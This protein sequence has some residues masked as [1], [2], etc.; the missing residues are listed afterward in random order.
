VEEAVILAY[1]TN[2]ATAFNLSPDSII[3]LNDIGVPAS[4]VSAM[5]QRDQVLKG[6]P[7]NNSV[8]A[9]PATVAPTDQYAPVPEMPAPDMA[10]VPTAPPDEVATDMG[11]PPDYGPADASLQPPDN[12]AY[13]NFYDALAPYGTWVDV[14]GYGACWQ[15]TA[16]IGN[17][18]WQPYFNCGHWVYTDCGWYWMSGYSWG[19]APF[20]YGR[21]FRH[22]R[23]GWCWA[24]ETTWG[25]SWV[26]W[27]YGATHCAWA[28]LPPG[29]WYR[30][31]VGLTF[32]GKP[33]GNTFGFG[34]SARSY[35]VV[36]FNHFWDHHLNRYALPQQQASQVIKGTVVSASVLGSNNRIINNG[37]PPSRVAAATGTSIHRITVHDSYA[38]SVHGVRA[39]RLESSGTSLSVF[40]PGFSPQAA[41][42]PA[43]AG[44][45]NRNAGQ[46]YSAGRAAPVYE[47]GNAGQRGTGNSRPV[48]T[49]I[50]PR[51]SLIVTGRKDS[52]SGRPFS[53]ASPQG[54]PQ[55]A[56]TTRNN[57]PG[58]NTYRRPQEQEGFVADVQRPPSQAWSP[59]PP[60]SVERHYAAPGYQAPEVPKA[61][62][63]PAYN[64][65]QHTYTAPAPSYTPRSEPVESHATYSPPPAAAPSAPA[66]HSH[67]ST[68]RYGR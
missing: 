26:C 60:A 23:L 55:A 44:W 3:Y 19:W 14:A 58:V 52:A 65:P 56:A 35:A 20:H 34:L 41:T 42:Q 17:P 68:D 40:R 45:L 50:T 9:A 16:V 63:A 10:P 53:Y 1:V 5:I 38:P 47:A 27:R 46:N 24:P 7:A 30:T 8:A 25:P 36:P 29:A 39:E 57:S 22:N 21:W 37:L 64:P 31:G 18:Y 51:G 61:A 4:V 28:P 66:A 6:L 12:G 2:A 54:T 13:A 49:E 33:I 48:V 59:P 15:P 32:R 11:P 67:S 43:A 62:P